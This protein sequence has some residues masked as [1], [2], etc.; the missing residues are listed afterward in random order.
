MHICEQSHSIGIDESIFWPFLSLVHWVFEKFCVQLSSRFAY[1][2][3]SPVCM[4][5][6]VRKR[7]DKIVHLHFVHIEQNV[8]TSGTFKFW[9]K[10]HGILFSMWPI[11]FAIWLAHCGPLEYGTIWT[12]IITKNHNFH[13]KFP[14]SFSYFQNLFYIFE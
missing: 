5:V 3:H 4:C 8:F 2:T 7:C 12:L 6:C 9:A 1:I 11:N 14:V 10:L 13:V